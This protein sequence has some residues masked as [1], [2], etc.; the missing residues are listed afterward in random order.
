MKLKTHKKG[1][2]CS[3]DMGYK[4]DHLKQ[5]SEID[6]EVTCKK[7]LKLIRDEKVSKAYEVSFYDWEYSFNQKNIKASS[8]S[9]AIYKCFKSF[10]YNDEACEGIG[11]Q[12]KSFL[13]YCNPKAKILKD[14]NIKPSLTEEE[15]NKLK[16]DEVIKRADEFN[17]KYPIGTEVLFQADFTDEVIVTTIRSKAQVYSHYLTIF[18]DGVSGSYHLDDRFVRVLTDENKD[19]ERLR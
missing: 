11:K 5:Y 17:S 2:E 19:L 16:K 3:S 14:K 15:E 1:L 13:L 4:R 12:F 7:C 8:S 18:L 6:N 9:S 10:R